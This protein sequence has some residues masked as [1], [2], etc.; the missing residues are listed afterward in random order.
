MQAGIPLQVLP[1][2]GM[3]VVGHQVRQEL[4]ILQQARVNV[5]LSVIQTTHE[6]VVVV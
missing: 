6:T 2:R 1:R 4:I 3:E 5:G